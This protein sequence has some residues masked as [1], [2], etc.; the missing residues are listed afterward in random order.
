MAHYVMRFIAFFALLTLDATRFLCFVFHKTFS[1][2]T[3]TENQ[4]DDARFRR[5]NA[6]IIEASMHRA[7]NVSAFCYAIVSQTRVNASMVRTDTERVF[8]CICRYYIHHQHESEPKTAPQKRPPARPTAIIAAAAVDF[9][10]YHYRC[11]VV[12]TDKSFRTFC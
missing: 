5:L 1:Q 4:H 3:Q 2:P 9:A 7:L 10:F 12:I 6:P 8:K 11:I